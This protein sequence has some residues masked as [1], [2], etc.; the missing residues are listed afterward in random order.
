MIQAY[1][2][3]AASYSGVKI[4]GDDRLAET[5]TELDASFAATHKSAE[6]ILP[7]RVIARAK[8]ELSHG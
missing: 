6:V 4:F 1:S 7:E 5:L 3:L 2:A 8:A